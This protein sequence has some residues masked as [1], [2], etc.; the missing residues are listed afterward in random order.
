MKTQAIDQVE[1][2]VCDHCSTIPVSHLS[3]DL[4]AP[5]VGW[6]ISLEGRGIQLV[7]DD[8]GR[9]AISRADFA[10]LIAEQSDRERRS[11]EEAR[12]RAEEAQKRPVVVGVPAVE[13]ASARESMLAAAGLVTPDQE[14]GRREAPRLLEEALDAGAKALA[15]KRAKTAARNR[16]RA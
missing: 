9:Q 13:G 1:P 3:L 2:M 15:E 10:G 5:T 8:L 16:Q 14:F 6:A 4:N 7:T 12:R 11:V